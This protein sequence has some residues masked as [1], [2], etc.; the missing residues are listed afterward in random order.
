MIET[1]KLPADLSAYPG[2]AQLNREL[3]DG[4]TRLDWSEVREASADQL[5]LLLDG[6]DLS[7]DA[8]VLGLSTVPS[9]I[10]GQVQAVLDRVEAPPTLPKRGRQGKKGS[11]PGVWV[12]PRDPVDGP[13]RQ[14]DSGEA[15]DDPVNPGHGTILQAPSP[16]R[17]REEFERLVLADLLGPAG[18]PEEEVAERSIRDRYLVGAIAPRRVALAP[19]EDDDFVL[20]GGDSAEEGSV[21]PGAN[22]PESMFPSSLGLTFTV[23]GAT[24]ALRVTASWGRYERV[25]SETATNQDTGTALRVWKRIPRGGEPLEVA[26]AEG[27]IGPLEVDPEQPEVVV[28]GVVRRR[29]EHWSV[30]LF[31][32]NGQEEPE[33]LRDSAWLFQPE[34]VV[35]DAGGEAVFLR[36]TVRRRGEHMDPAVLAEEEAMEMLY[37]HHLEFAVGHG[38]SVHA[39]TS[40]QVPTR[41]FRVSTRVVPAY[42]VPL[43]T[44][45]TPAEIPELEG[46]VLDMAE[47]GRL[48][49]SELVDALGPLPGAYAKW[50]ER[51]KARVDQEPE[52]RPYKR[53]AEGALGECGQALQRIQAG[54]ELLGS[55]PRAA[56]AFRFMNQA[57]ALQRLHTMYAEAKRRGDDV[58][59]DGLD[60]PSN[61]S[62]RPFQLAFI[63]LNLPGITQLDHPDRQAGADAVTGLLWFPTGGGKTEAYLGLTAYTVGLR[64]LQGLVEGRSGEHGVAVLMRYT[65]RLLTLQQFQRATAL[66]CACESIRRESVNDGKAPWGSEPFRIGL[67]VGNRMTPNSVT[68]SA[69]AVKREHGQYRRSN[70]FSSGSP[71][72]LTNCPWCGTAIDSGRNIKVEP[73]GQGR[74]RT[75]MYCGDPLGRCPFTERNSPGEGLP[76]V[77]VDEEIYRRLPAL[78]I[79]TVDKFAQ[80]PW[81]GAVEM[82]FGQVDGKCERHGFRSPEI[83]DSDSHPARNPHP[84]ARTLPANPLRPPDLIIQDELHLIS[85]PLGSLMGAYETAID[86][87]ATWEVGGR[88]VR[89][90]VIASTATIRRAEDQVRALFLRKVEVFPPYGL[91]AGDNFFA[92]QRPV[93]E[94][95]PGRRYIGICA[96]GRRLKAVLIRVYVAH[97]AAA[98]VLFEKYGQAADPYMTLVGYFNSMR[99]LAGMHRLVDDDVRSRLRSTDQRGLAKRQP[100]IVEEL[101]SRKSSTDIPRVLD[102]L[103]TPFDPAKRGDGKGKGR[104]SQEVPPIDVLLATNMVSVGVDVRRLGLMVVAGQPKTTAEYIQATSRVGRVYPG[105]VCTVFNWARPRDLSHYERFE[106]Y[107]AT[108]Y[109]QVEAISVT[110]FAPR[111]LDRSLTALLVSLIRLRGG[112]FNENSRAG[113]ITRDHPYVKSAVEAIRN[114]AWN[115]SLRDDLRDLVEAELDQRV[116]EWLSEARRTEGG[117]VVGYRDKKDGQTQGLLKVPSLEPWDTFTCLNSLRD[118]EPTINLILDDG[119]LDDPGPVPVASAADGGGE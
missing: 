33:T 28:Q 53:T 97:L 112:E 4:V 117:R 64:R 51:Q 91:D 62:W 94:E 12:A 36:R 87:L 40:P 63:L 83:E 5:A 54:I 65:L 76:V 113:R 32:V 29:E 85:G 89:P 13:A 15:D 23:D 109:Q 19:E 30:T 61:R 60:V 74:A 82:L 34:L 18:G 1:K 16:Y 93:S 69:E 73:Y 10:E 38:V 98:Q 106:H 49:G 6:L 39:D 24:T 46:I 45:P 21:D 56:E 105:L 7:D 44:T 52:L 77:V 27:P 50:I 102:R 47:L 25:A 68:Q 3:R 66:I 14:D 101:T 11:R 80:M 9:Q 104:S 119:A 111:A 70:G 55:D 59:L 95:Y 22:L 67:W 35:E 108:F 92:L 26:L 43:T 78:L 88:R 114:R 41:A 115:V 107:H 58:T 99:E 37:R 17:I 81:N 57:M 86:E 84:R 103:E 100:P 2:L 96:Q 20:A 31:L 110:P 71:A 48:T 116:D 72:Q 75:L 42:E 79:A 8:E 90:K 118:V